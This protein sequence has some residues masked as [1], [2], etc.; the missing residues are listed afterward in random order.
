MSLGVTEEHRVL[1]TSIAGW[2]TRYV[3]RD[4]VRAGLGSRDRPAFWPSLAGQGLLGMHLPEEYGGAGY[5]LAE[6][7]EALAGTGRALVPG[8]FLPTALASAVL[9]AAASPE[10]AKRLLPGLADGSLT[11]AVALGDS[12]GGLSAERTGEGWRVHGVARPVLGG[13]HADL[14][15]L[16]ATETA[17]KAGDA[18][19]GSGAAD[20]GT[21][22]EIWFVLDVSGGTSQ[23]RHLR[24]LPSLDPTRPLAEIVLD[25]LTVPA[26]NTLPGLGTEQVQDL[27]ATLFAAEA[28][29]IAAW[30]VETAA[31]YAKVREQFGR[32]IGA[33]QAVKH[34][35]AGH[36]RTAERPPG[37]WP[38]TRRGRDAGARE[39]PSLRPRRR[40]PRSTPR[41][42]CAKD[43]IQVLGGIG[44]TWEH[45][46]HLYLR[47]ALALRQLLGGDRGAGA[48]APPR[49]ALAGPRRDLGVDLPAEAA[50]VRRRGPRR[51][52][53]SSPRSAGPDAVSRLADGGL[54][55]TAP[56][57]TVGSL[58]RRR[59]AGRHRRRSCA[60]AGLRMPDLVIANWV[61]P[62]LA[63]YGSEEQQRRFIPPTLRG[64]IIW[65]QMFSEPGAGSDL[66][67]L[68]TRAE[69]VRRRL[70]AHRRRRCGPR[71][72]G[73]AHWA[74]CLARTDPDPPKHKGLTYFLRR[75]VGAGH[76]RPAAARDHRRRPVQ[77]GLPD[78]VF[79]PD[80]CVVGEVGRGL[81]GGPDHARQRAGAHGPGSVLGGG[82]EGLLEHAAS[83][84]SG[85][86]DPVAL[87]RLGRLVAEGQSLALLGLRATLR[88]LEGLDAGPESS[89]RKLLAMGHAQEIA[90]FGL[91]LLG[92]EGAITELAAATWVRSFLAS[93]ALSIAGG[94]TEVQRNVVA[95]RLLGLPRDP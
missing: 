74:I 25:G 87:D 9:A 46:A 56:A 45:D 52:A 39:C 70:A 60:A 73:E 49:L 64:E 94:T 54:R 28:A 78:G 40:R 23:V 13:A 66:A 51:T 15:V 89:V 29:G 55:R 62:T 42:T 79:V 86:L 92:P 68:T 58:G 12:G 2:A 17:A 21:G 81:A 71:W 3:P 20:A 1:A 80:D 75:H 18:G 83:L 95:E 36:A 57:T 27:A 22:G 76:R 8:P 59:R 41:S 31:E 85:R 6:L 72:P 65:C 11:G 88:R 38:G 5:G 16:P 48:T 93:R 19:A 91:D 53:P 61:M 7:A 67:A 33:F 14:L 44:F 63:T 26:E 90:E 10:L 32:P 43:C 82:V 30:C 69:R 84:G 47:R 4:A 35:C 37:R 77:R 34:L 24:M 50:Q